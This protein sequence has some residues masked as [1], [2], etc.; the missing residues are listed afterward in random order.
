MSKSRKPRKKSLSIP[1]FA[2]EDEEREFWA[3]HDTADYFDWSRAV[4][5][6]FPNLKPST[7]TISIRLPD[8]ML[9]DLKVLANDRDVPYQSLMKV[10]LAE[11]L[12]AERR[13][14][15]RVSA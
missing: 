1:R 15:R 5:A 3:T 10:F 13:G 12:A 7:T 14:K 4:V 11:R 8:G 6:S 9:Q 2:S